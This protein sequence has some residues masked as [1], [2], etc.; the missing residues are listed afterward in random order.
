M[1]L[2]KQI[3]LYPLIGIMSLGLLGCSPSS[4][5]RKIDK[6]NQKID[7]TID[8]SRTER[9]KLE[10]RLF[11]TAQGVYPKEHDVRAE[12]IY[13]MAFYIVW[14]KHGY[15]RREADG[16]ISLLPVGLGGTGIEIAE[17][18]KK[19]AG[20]DNLVSLDELRKARKRFPSDY[21]PGQY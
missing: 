2:H 14:A 3:I 4:L 16:S 8:Q 20:D 10:E 11:V 12:D 18:I 9:T 13:K 5:N 7:G 19:I 21:E 15:A 1:K 6:L 17:E